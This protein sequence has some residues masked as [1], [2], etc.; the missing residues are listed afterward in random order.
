M[1]NSKD[2]PNSSP[3]HDEI[4]KATIKKKRRDFGYDGGKPRVPSGD[5][6]EKTWE[7][8]RKGTTPSKRKKK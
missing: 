2:K 4:T 6:G 5:N 7:P 8:P 1:A 3:S